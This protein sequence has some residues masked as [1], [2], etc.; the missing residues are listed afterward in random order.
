MPALTPSFRCGSC[1]VSNANISHDAAVAG[2]ML[3][4]FAANRGGLDQRLGGFDQISAKVVQARCEARSPM[5]SDP[6]CG[7]KPGETSGSRGRPSSGRCQPDLGEFDQASAN[8]DRIRAEPGKFGPASRRVEEGCATFRLRPST[9]AGRA[10]QLR[11]GA[12]AMSLPL[13]RFIFAHSGMNVRTGAVP[14]G[15]QRF[16]RASSGPSRTVVEAPEP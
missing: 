16:R 15:G 9:R 1:Q 8:V 12:T 4:G 13:G 7:P 10:D 2:Q 3:D 14:S 6:E 11:E 5:R